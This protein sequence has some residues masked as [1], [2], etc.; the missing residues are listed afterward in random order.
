MR[1]F[2]AVLVAMLA[3]ASAVAAV[4][5]A[6]KGP[7]KIPLPDGYQPEGIAAGKGR[8]VYV[9]SIPTGRVLE[10]DTKTGAFEEAVPARDEHAAIGLKYDK[11]ANRL[12]VSG[13]PTGKAFV[14]DASSGAELAAFQL[15]PAGP[16][17]IGR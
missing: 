16:E 3:A 13:G 2:L 5:I 10:I 17:K 1:R 11:H 4:A 12:F 14:Y 8:S 15:T 9:G 6:S 7:E